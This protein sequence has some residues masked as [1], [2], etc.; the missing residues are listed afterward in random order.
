MSAH[1][2]FILSILEQQK[3]LEQKK[4]DIETKQI[5]TYKLSRSKVGQLGYGRFYSSIGGL[6]T[7]EKECR[8]TSKNKFKLFSLHR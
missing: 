2:K 5:V 6:E 1:T 7:V 8:G 4:K 3:P